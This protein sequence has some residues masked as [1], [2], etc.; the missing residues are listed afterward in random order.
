MCEDKILEED[1]YLFMVINV[2]IGI[3]AK[4]RYS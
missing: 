2:K 4:L 1:E 3:Y